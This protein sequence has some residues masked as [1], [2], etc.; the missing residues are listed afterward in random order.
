LA[1]EYPVTS[2]TTINYTNRKNKQFDFYVNK[3]FI[4][5][6]LDVDTKQIK[7]IP[8]DWQD[9]NETIPELKNYLDLL[10]KNP[11]IF[12]T[13]SISQFD[14]QTLH[15]FF[16]RLPQYSQ[17]NEACISQYHPPGSDKNLLRIAL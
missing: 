11:G 8:N 7:P 9:E 2:E 6:L 4:A 12:P 16:T 5:D 10:P 3:Q 13:E 1:K 17:I 14:K 15:P